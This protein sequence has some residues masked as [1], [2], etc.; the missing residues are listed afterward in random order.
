V[1]EANAVATL[2]KPRGGRPVTIVLRNEK[3]DTIETYMMGHFDSTRQVAYNFR[4]E[5][6][7]ESDWRQGRTNRYELFTDNDAKLVGD[8]W[9]MGMQPRHVEKGHYEEKELPVQNIPTEITPAMLEQQTLGL[10]VMTASDLAAFPDDMDKQIELAQRRAVPLAGVVIMLVGV[11]LIL[12][13]EREDPGSRVGRVKSIIYAI[14]VCAVYYLAQNLF[15]GFSE[16]GHLGAN[17]TAWMPNILFGAW[18]VR[19]FRNVNL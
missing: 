1:R 15:V 8:Q 7:Q 16:R 5:I 17:V 3:N 12:R 10:A 14:G 6:R 13:R 9:R 2:M 11:S 18:A 4:L 19:S